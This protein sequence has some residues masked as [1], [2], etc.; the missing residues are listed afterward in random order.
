L[1]CNVVLVSGI[2]DTAIP[3]SASFSSDPLSYDVNIRKIE[4]RVY[5]CESCCV[6]SENHHECEEFDLK[7]WILLYTL[8][9]PTLTRTQIT[10]SWTQQRKGRAGGME[11]A[12]LTH[13]HSYVRNREPV[14]RRCVTRSSARY[15]DDLG[16]VGWGALEGG[17]IYP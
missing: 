5:P 2:P 16:L 10:D 4:E 14:G 13:I 12:A 11:T 17:D 7:N 6:I 1:L 15:H 8:I 3:I 9:Q